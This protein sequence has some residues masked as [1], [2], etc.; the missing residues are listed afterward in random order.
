MKN[1]AMDAWDAR[2]AAAE[3]SA[4]HYLFLPAASAA[5]AVRR[6]T[7]LCTTL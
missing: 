1:I 5:A 3:T 4:D 2:P 6:K 7:A